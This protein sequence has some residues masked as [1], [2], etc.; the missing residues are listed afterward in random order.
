M[1][2]WLKRD[3]TVRVHHNEGI[4]LVCLIDEILD[5]SGGL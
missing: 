4:T 3:D 2:G 1:P 5:N